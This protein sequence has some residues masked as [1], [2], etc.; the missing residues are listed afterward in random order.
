MKLG[1]INLRA[2]EQR[3]ILKKSTTVP[4]LCKIFSNIQKEE[5]GISVNESN[6]K[7]PGDMKTIYNNVCK[8]FIEEDNSE[9]T[10]I[11]CIVLLK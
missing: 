5:T 1:A 8:I 9:L 6:L 4:V 10:Y 7:I 11:I 3:W 2:A